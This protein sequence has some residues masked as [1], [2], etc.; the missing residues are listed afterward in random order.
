MSILNR[1]V[2]TD[3]KINS[4]QILLN[5]PVYLLGFTKG[6]WLRFCFF[7]FSEASVTQSQMQKWKKRPPPNQSTNKK[8]KQISAWI[9]LRKTVFLYFPVC[10]AGHSFN[11]IL[12]SKCYCLYNL[13]GGSCGSCV[14]QESCEICKCYFL[15]LKKPSSRG[16]Y[17]NL[18]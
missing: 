12:L 3:R 14:F 9:R 8:Q 17:L 2:I 11:H 10:Q 1:K 6:I 4:F 5:E 15:S 18:E 16:D 7:V 13:G